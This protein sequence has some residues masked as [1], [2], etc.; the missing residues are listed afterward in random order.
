MPI[1]HIP[2]RF[3]KLKPKLEPEMIELRKSII[4]TE[5]N[6]NIKT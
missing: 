2:G 1:S 6:E 3:S 5:P 4:K